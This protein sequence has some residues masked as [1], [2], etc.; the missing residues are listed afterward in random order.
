MFSLLTEQGCFKDEIHYDEQSIV[1]SDTDDACEI[2]HCCVR[3]SLLH[4]YVCMLLVFLHK[5]EGKVVCGNLSESC[6]QLNCNASQQVTEP[7]KCCARCLNGKQLID[8][9]IWPTIDLIFFYRKQHSYSR[10]TR[11]I[12]T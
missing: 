9:M 3:T 2:C 5:Q 10:T 11:Y 6:P 8:L 1:S 7:G 4:F 12:H